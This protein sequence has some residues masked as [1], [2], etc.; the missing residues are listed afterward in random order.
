MYSDIDF[1]SLLTVQHSKSLLRIIQFLTLL[2]SS[3]ALYFFVFPF[4]FV[5][6]RKLKMLHKWEGLFFSFALHMPKVNHMMLNHK[7]VQPIFQKTA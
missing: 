1:L 5:H 7:I 2:L 6:F 3:P 4:A